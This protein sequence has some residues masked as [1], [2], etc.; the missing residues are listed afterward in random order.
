MGDF[1][2][3]SEA[4]VRKRIS[5]LV[6]AAR[7]QKNLTQLDVARSLG[8]SQS[9]VSKI[10]AGLV[11]PSVIFWCEFCKLAE[12]GSQEVYESGYID[13]RHLIELSS[14]ERVG[15][16]RLPRRYC[17]QRGST[18]RA[19]MPLI[20]YFKMNY[21]ERELIRYLES[22]QIDP[23]FFIVLN[24]SLNIQFNLDL[25]ALLLEKGGLTGAGLEALT[26]PLRQP[27]MHGNLHRLYDA[28]DTEKKLLSSFLQNI[29]HYEVNFDYS[30]Q[31][32]SRQGL[33]VAIT[34]RDHMTSFPYRSAKLGTILCDYKKQYFRSFSAYGGRRPVEVTEK[35][36]HFHGHSRCLYQVRWA[37]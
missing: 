31:S 10:E 8:V 1:V 33:D 24:N 28:A 21:G 32:E 14:G 26:R 3:D 29:G 7:K 22:V 2:A 37:V 25:L 12:I 20:N 30:L 11:T 13:Q 16:F 4:V 15:K 9:S 34:P 17:F 5:A 18:V 19:S 27:A 35:E 6:R 36:C 23:D